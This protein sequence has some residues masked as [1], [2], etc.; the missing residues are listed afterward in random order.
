MSLF[1]ITGLLT[2]HLNPNCSANILFHL[3]DYSFWKKDKLIQSYLL[4]KE[5]H[6]QNLLEYKSYNCR[7]RVI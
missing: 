3:M 4:K 2:G 5:S 6:E 7:F 1:E